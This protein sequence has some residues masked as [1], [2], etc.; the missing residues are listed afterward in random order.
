VEKMMEWVIWI[1]TVV[2][3]GIGVGYYIRKYKKPDLLIGLYVLFLAAAQIIAV[4]IITVGPFVVPASIFIYPFTLLLIDCMVEFFGKQEAY[5]AIGICFVSQV[6]LVLL[7]WLSIIAS[8]VEFWKLQD[9]WEKIF[10]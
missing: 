6:V 9:P 2:L 3:S 10:T 5:R 8:P 4:K 1:L 7:L